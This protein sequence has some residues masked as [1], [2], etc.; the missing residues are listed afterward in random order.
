MQTTSHLLM[1]RPAS[2][3]FNPETAQTN[4][5]QKKASDFSE[6]IHKKALAEFDY[7]VELLKKEDLNVMVI[8]DTLEPYKPDAIFPNNWIT[9]HQEGVIVLYPMQAPN[10]RV[11]RRIDIVEILQKQYKVHNVV[12]LSHYEAKGKF[13]E[14]TGS[15]IFEHTHKIAY[16]SLS[17]RTNTEVLDRF[18][19]SMRFQP[20]TFQALD[21]YDKPIY[22]TNVLMSVGDK[23]VII[24]MDAIKEPSDQEDLIASFRKTQKEI[25]KISYEQMK[26]FVANCLEVT[27][28]KGERILILSERAYQHLEESQRKRLENYVKLLPCPLETIETYGG[29]SARCMIA[30]IFLPK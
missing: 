21:E 15:M 22:H 2:F 28:N 24:C 12:N 20:V 14:G 29:G 11:E 18:C 17:S 7:M 10:R 1:I 25:F 30:E 13:L 4:V 3:G 26:N 16:A 19:N 23:F 6:E 8:D 9:T 5:F 27:N